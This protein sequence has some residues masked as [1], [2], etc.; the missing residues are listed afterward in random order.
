MINYSKYPLIP[1][2]AQRP[3]SCNQGVRVIKSMWS[4]FPSVPTI[5]VWIPIP[6][7]PASDG[8]RRKREDVKCE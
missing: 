3:R 6:I 5:S 2:C 7:L 4:L 1:H 8:M